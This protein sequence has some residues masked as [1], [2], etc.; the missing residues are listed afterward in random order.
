MK[1]LL[2]KFSFFSILALTSF[3]FLSFTQGIV[4]LDKNHKKSTKEEGVFYRP[5]PEK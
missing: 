2:S 3:L 4:W 5:I 1:T